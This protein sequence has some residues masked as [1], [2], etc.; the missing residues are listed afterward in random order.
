MNNKKSRQSPPIAYQVVRCDLLTG[1]QAN[2]SVGGQQPSNTTK[3]YNFTDKP[4][5]LVGR[6]GTIT[7]LNPIRNTDSTFKGL[8]CHT[9]ISTNTEIDTPHGH[10]SAL[11]A[12]LTNQLHANP[13]RANVKAVIDQDTIY[14]NRYGI[15]LID[16]DVVVTTNEDYAKGLNHPDCEQKRLN[17]F[18]KVGMDDLQG[19]QTIQIGVRIIDNAGIIGK[20]FTVIHGQ[21]MEIYAIHSAHHTDGVYI[22]GF[23]GMTSPSTSKPREVEYYTF[24]AIAK[25]EG[26]IQL[27]ETYGEALSH[28]EEN[29]QALKE[30]ELQNKKLDSDYKTE[31]ERLKQENAMQVERLK[32]RK[33]YLDGENQEAKF[34]QDQ[35]LRQSEYES[36]MQ[37]ARLEERQNMQKQLIEFTK[38]MGIVCTLVISIVAMV[39]SKK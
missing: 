4:L 39:K 13:K 36:R 12:V 24:E 30:L 37:K 31:I 16:F 21:I 7:R 3:Y 32:V 18:L 29:N 23:N 19:Q 17:D 5:F 8:V 11:N 22:S 14:S 15:Y 28:I 26:P 1:D 25:K 33:H 34:Q 9:D 27:F 6:L 35:E 2:F 20:R 10:E 38:T